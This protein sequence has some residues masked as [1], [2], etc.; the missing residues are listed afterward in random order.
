[1]AVSQKK[2]CSIHVVVKFETFRIK[3]IKVQKSSTKNKV[4][5]SSKISKDSFIARVSPGLHL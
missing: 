3:F 5:K 4:Q 1:V 2:L